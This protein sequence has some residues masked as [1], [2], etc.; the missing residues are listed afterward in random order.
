MRIAQDVVARLGSLRSVILVGRW[1]T[2]SILNP[3]FLVT[4]PLPSLRTLVLFPSEDGDYCEFER[5]WH[6]VATHL[7]SLRQFIVNGSSTDELPVGLLG[8][9]STT[10]VVPRSSSFKTRMKSWTFLDVEFRNLAASFSSLTHLHIFTFDFQ[11]NLLDDLALLP[12]TL[13]ILVLEVG[14]DC[15]RYDPQSYPKL[16]RPPLLVF[17]EY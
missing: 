1:I 13:R 3:F 4:D 7:P 9:S 16:A 10:H 6:Y 17:F 12:P 14:D 11:S 8:I 15:P 2:F 5:L